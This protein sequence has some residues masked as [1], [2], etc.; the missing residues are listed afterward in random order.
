[1]KG[2]KKAAAD[3]IYVGKKT[4]GF[5]WVRVP[6]QRQYGQLA[7]AVID[8]AVFKEIEGWANEASAL[9]RWFMRP[10]KHS[11]TIHNPPTRMLN[12]MSNRVVMYMDS[13]FPFWETISGENKYTRAAIN[14]FDKY[15][16]MTAYLAENAQLD[17]SVLSTHGTGGATAVGSTVDELRALS[18]TATPEVRAALAEAGIV[19]LGQKGGKVRQ[20]W[21]NQVTKRY[22]TRREADLRK[23]NRID[24][25]DRVSL[26]YWLTDGPSKLSRE[27]ALK[28]IE[29]VF[30][31]YRTS[32]AFLRSMSAFPV[33]FIMYSARMVPALS[34]MIGENPLR[35]AGLMATIAAADQIS[36]YT[37]GRGTKDNDDR[38]LPER[39]RQG[40]FGYGMPGPVQ[41]PLKGDWFSD[42]ER[43][44]RAFVNTARTMPMSAVTEGGPMGMGAARP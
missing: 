24:N 16:S 12:R 37:V 1:M 42:K 25:V 11:L 5:A 39:V 2:V 40:F 8:R 38:L 10:I 17:H 34:K 9:Q 19:P 13:G 3:A 14:D 36:K 23:Y 20:A 43:D 4:K 32:S 22:L 35:W 28:H 30:P 21:D 31:T 6:N 18:E 15:G 26:M 7:G 29:K 27:E 44:T 41:L 33:P